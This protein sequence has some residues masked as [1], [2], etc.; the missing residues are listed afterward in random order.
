MRK[1]ITF[2]A[3]LFFSS[4]VSGHTIFQVAT[5]VSSPVTITNT[6]NRN[7]MSTVSPKAISLASEFPTMM[8]YANSFFSFVF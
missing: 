6:L 1:H 4:S 3:L 7:S 8:V 5:H 2:A